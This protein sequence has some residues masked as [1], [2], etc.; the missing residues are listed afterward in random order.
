MR[1]KLKR[2]S[3]GGQQDIIALASRMSEKGPVQ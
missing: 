1:L 2:L 3:D